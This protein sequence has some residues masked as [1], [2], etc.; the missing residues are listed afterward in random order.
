MNDA[1][2]VS[3]WTVNENEKVRFV[4]LQADAR[5]SPDLQNFID[6]TEFVCEPHMMGCVN[7]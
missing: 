2:L 7:I 6:V 1:R 5:N 3:S 4:Y